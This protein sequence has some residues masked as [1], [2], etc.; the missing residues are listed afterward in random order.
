MSGISFFNMNSSH[1][2][3]NLVSFS[4]RSSGFQEI[5]YTGLNKRIDDSLKN[6]FAA[7]EKHNPKV[8]NNL[9]HKVDRAKRSTDYKLIQSAYIDDPNADKLIHKVNIYDDG[10][11]RRLYTSKRPFAQIKYQN[12]KITSDDMLAQAIR[13]KVSQCLSEFQ[14]EF[15]TLLECDHLKEKQMNISFYFRG[16]GTKGQEIPF[17]FCGDIIRLNFCSS[18]LGDKGQLEN[19]DAALF[20]SFFISYFDVTK[21]QFNGN[22]RGMSNQL[23]RLIYGLSKALAARAPYSSCNIKG[24]Y[25]SERHICRILTGK[26]PLV[27][28]IQSV[29]NDRSSLEMFNEDR[30]ELCLLGEY[31]LSEQKTFVENLL[32]SF[33]TKNFQAIN[34]CISNLLSKENEFIHFLQTHKGDVFQKGLTFKNNY[35]LIESVD[36][37]I[38]SVAHKI[39]IYDDG[40]LRRLYTSKRPFAQIKYQNVKITSDD[41]LAQ[42]IRSKVSQ[43]LSEFQREFST[44]LECDHLKEKQMNISFYFRGYGTKGQEIPFSFC[45]DIIRLNFCSSYLGDKGQLEN[46]DAALFRSFFISYFDVTKDQFNGNYRGMSNQL[47]RLIYGLSKALAARAPYSSC[48]ERGKILSRKPSLTD[49]QAVLNNTCNL[50][51]FNKDRSEL[52][53]LGE[54]LLSEQKTFVEN[55]LTSFRTKDFK[56]I[57]SYMSNFLSGKRDILQINLICS[58]NLTNVSI[59]QNETDVTDQEMS[60]FFDGLNKIRIQ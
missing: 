17:S 22:Y 20:R 45:G 15:S 10:Y 5:P 13:S 59:I 46:L 56:K 6:F 32:T 24:F 52:C 43:C 25:P 41:M 37:S 9:V 42:A 60:N 3:N 47:Y 11:L 14:R 28:D 4:N 51:F 58:T 36:T 19:L 31:L 21:D 7:S 27:I 57:N 23:Y 35:E 44:L 18:Y 39:D 1:L 50:D 29:L 16:Y 26:P 49:I 30:L 34:S 2:G 55:L 40:Y 12:V 54:Y 48:N 53:L 8:K 33:K 38:D